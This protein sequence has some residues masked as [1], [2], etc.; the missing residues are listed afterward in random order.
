MHRIQLTLALVLL[1]L[2]ALCQV[3]EHRN[4]LAIGVS[5]GYTLN[6]ISFS[7]TIKQKWHGGYNGGL[8]IR[9]TCEKYFSALCALQAEVNYAQLGWRE[10][11]ETSNDT[12]LRTM[13]YV[14]V[15]LLARLAW[16]REE[17]GVQAFLALGPQLGYC[18]G[19]SEE[20]GGEWSEATLSLRPNHVTMQY[21]MPVGKRFEYGIT[22]GLGIEINTRHA[23]HF[24]LEGRYYYALSDIYPNGK[25]DIFGRSANGAI[26]ARCAYLFDV[27]RTKK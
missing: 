16:G 26:Y 10:N 13:N 17:G 5:G 23:G 21:D 15:P 8:T 7:P 2:P 18:L 25:K 14:Q 6:R 11:I 27:I 9:Y 4:D 22:G 20:R 19:E 12:Y 1:S 3:G 24:I